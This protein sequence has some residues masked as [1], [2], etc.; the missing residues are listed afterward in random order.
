M[1]ISM[2]TSDDDNYR[3]AGVSLYMY[4]S[5]SRENGEI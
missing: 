4:V 5:M 2:H 1:S 3:G